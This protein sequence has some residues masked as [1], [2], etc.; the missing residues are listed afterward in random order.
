[1]PI[2]IINIKINDTRLAPT[3]TLTLNIGITCQCYWTIVITTASCVSGIT[4]KVMDEFS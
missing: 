1:M 3:T 2:V 4:Q